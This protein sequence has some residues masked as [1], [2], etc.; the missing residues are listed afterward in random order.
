M[1]NWDMESIIG[2]LAAA[3]S[4]DDVLLAFPT[5][6]RVQVQPVWLMPHV[7]QLLSYSLLAKEGTW[8][9]LHS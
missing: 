9:N 3:D 4:V 5:L 7:A 2:V 6:T 8:H 1:I